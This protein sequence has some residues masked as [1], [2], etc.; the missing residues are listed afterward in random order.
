MQRTT[1]GH[2]QSA[3]DFIIE[4]A[5]LLSRSLRET[6][7][8]WLQLFL[9]PV[10]NAVRDPTLFLTEERLREHISGTET[11]NRLFPSQCFISHNKMNR[12]CTNGHE[13]W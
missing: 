2:E 8:N 6:E 12:R 3:S 4:S 7:A 1:V 5:H 11:I 9:D 13:I 10:L